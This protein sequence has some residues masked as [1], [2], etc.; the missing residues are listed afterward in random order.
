MWIQPCIVW[1]KCES[2][3]VLCG[4]NVNPAVYCVVSMWIQLCIVWCKC[5]FNIRPINLIVLIFNQYILVSS[6]WIRQT[7]PELNP[8]YIIYD[9]IYSGP[10]SLLPPIHMKTW[11]NMKLSHDLPQ[12]GLIYIYPYFSPNI[13]FFAQIKPHLIPIFRPIYVYLPIFSFIY[14]CL[15]TVLTWWQHT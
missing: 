2:S 15:V 3:R 14:S 6:Y 11:P 5:P 1:C 9:L 12:F 13:P 8:I 7:N 10:W 4:V